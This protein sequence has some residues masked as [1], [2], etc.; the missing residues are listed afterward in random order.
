MISV[1]RKKVVELGN[2][3]QHGIL[4]FCNWHLHATSLD[5]RWVGELGVDRLWASLG[6]L[7]RQTDPRQPVQ[8]QY[9]KLS[10]MCQSHPGFGQCEE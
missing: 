3:N 6:E 4:N 2:T 1:V 9:S 10:T 8:T 5:A 7:E